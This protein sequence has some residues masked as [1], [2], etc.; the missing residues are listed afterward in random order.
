LCADQIDEQASH[1]PGD[2][3]QEMPAVLPIDLTGTG[4]P[5]ESL[6]HERVVWSVPPGPLAP[7]AL[8]A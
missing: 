2:D 4:E 8:A 5:H 1:R 6:V 3:R 7:H